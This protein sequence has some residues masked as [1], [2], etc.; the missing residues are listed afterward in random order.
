MMKSVE[1]TKNL[2]LSSKP[3]PQKYTG[4]DFFQ[5]LDEGLKRAGLPFQTTPIQETSEDP[6]QEYEIRF[7]KG[8][9]E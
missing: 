9:R 2:E 4:E 5:E 1:G 8:R 7:F 6:T 3:Q